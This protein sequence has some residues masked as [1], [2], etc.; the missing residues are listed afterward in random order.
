[1][2]FSLNHDVLAK[3]L[4]S[5]TGGSRGVCEAICCVCDF[6]CASACPRSS[7]KMA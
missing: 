5:I 4:P 3:L 6:V 1:M 2:A 7:R